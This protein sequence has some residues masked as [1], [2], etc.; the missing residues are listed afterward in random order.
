[1]QYTFKVK[2]LKCPD[3]ASLLATNLQKS[4]ILKK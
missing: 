1:M 2:E 3:C 4:S